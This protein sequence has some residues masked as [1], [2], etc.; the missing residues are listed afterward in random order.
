VRDR[1]AAFWI[2]AVAATAVLVFGI[3]R[4]EIGEV[5]L[6]AALL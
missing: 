6:N 4:K 2:T 1:S 3:F 5:L